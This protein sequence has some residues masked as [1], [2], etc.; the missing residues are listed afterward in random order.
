MHFAAR[1]KVAV[2]LGKYD[3]GDEVANV[4]AAAGGKDNLPADVVDSDVG[5]N[6]R[7]LALHSVDNRSTVA[8]HVVT[9]AAAGD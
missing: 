3:V 4:V 8:H 5:S 1:G 2:T 7:V 9:L 6:A